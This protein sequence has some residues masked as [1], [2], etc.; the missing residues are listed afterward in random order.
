[1]LRLFS[2][3]ALVVGFAS[4]S[5]GAQGYILG[6]KISTPTGTA[7]EYI[8]GMFYVSASSQTASTPT[9]TLDG[10]KGSVFF[11]AISSATGIFYYGTVP[12]LYELKHRSLFLGDNAGSIHAADNTG[13][14]QLFGDNVGIGPYA[15]NSLTSD[16]SNFWG[17]FNTGVGSMA[18]Q[19]TADGSFANTFVGYEAG[20][21]NTSGTQNTYVGAIAGSQSVD[22]SCNTAVG[23]AAFYGD[24]HGSNNTAVGWTSFATLTGSAFT[25]SNSTAFGSIAL[26]NIPNGGTCNNSTAVGYASLYGCSGSANT[27]VGFETMFGITTG[28]QNIA[29]GNRA[30]FPTAGAVNVTTDTNMILIGSNA[31]KNTTTLLDGAGCIGPNCVVNQTGVFA[32]M[33]GAGSVGVAVSTPGLPVN[34]NFA[35]GNYLVGYSS[36]MVVVSSLTVAGGVNLGNVSKEIGIGA[37]TYDQ[38]N[39]DLNTG[40]GSSTQAVHLGAWK[41]WTPA[42]TGF[43]VNPTGVTARYA[44]TG[45]KV[46]AKFLA[47]AG[48]SN[49]TTFT[50]TLPVV[51]REAVDIALGQANDN[52]T[53]SAVPCMVVPRAASAIADVYKDLTAASW[54]N[55]NGKMCNFVI[56]YEANID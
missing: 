18:G 23:Q 32:L 22:S 10:T 34:A 55:A 42:Y 11:P 6:P 13:D 41:T 48:T 26:G 33:S 4:C 43:S 35:L 49:A 56:T 17:V 45:R 16:P 8:A 25:A 15:L 29:I 3:I 28:S 14:A 50:V 36:G 12:F 52:G 30:G 31:S 2:A 39:S 53:P 1:M 27:G 7:S 38:S 51:A 19:H 44:R 46:T 54:T 5:F 21:A 40:N 37:L 20:Q 24:L 9:I 47:T